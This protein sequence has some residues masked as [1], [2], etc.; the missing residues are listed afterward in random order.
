DAAGAAA[1]EKEIGDALSWYRDLSDFTGNG[2]TY[3]GAVTVT[4]K[5]THYEVRA[6][7]VALVTAA[8]FSA[9]LGTVVANARKGD[10]GAW[11]FSIALPETVVLRDAA[12]E[13][14]ADIRAATQRFSAAWL[15]GMDVMHKY[16]AEYGNI[17]IT[18]RG[19]GAQN[20]SLVIGSL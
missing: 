16:D 14:V 5:D 12:Q 2:I 10:D 20:V 4:P 1:L 15:P 17:T 13:P 11:L 8:G 3:K 9:D 19:E 7:G 6:A 18:P